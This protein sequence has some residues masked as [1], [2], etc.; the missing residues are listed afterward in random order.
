MKK[1]FY[2]LAFLEGQPLIYSIGR[3]DDES[4]ARDSQAKFNLNGTLLDEDQMAALHRSVDGVVEPRAHV[5]L[6]L[7][8][9]EHAALVE[10][11][12][13]H[14]GNIP[15]Y[16]DHLRREESQ[17]YA[18]GYDSDARQAR[19]KIDGMAKLL[20]RLYRLDFPQI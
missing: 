5:N 8:R 11:C 1:N 3:H 20:M 6:V 19:E 18:Q 15:A 4:S 7:Y 17:R 9:E 10:A 12:V 16:L 14:S 2:T 13:K